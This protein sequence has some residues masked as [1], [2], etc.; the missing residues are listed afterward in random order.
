MPS[1][2]ESFR[3]KQVET[4]EEFEAYYRLRWERLRKPWHQAEG[5]EQDDIEN[6]C[7][8]LIA[9]DKKKNVIGVARLQ[10]NN[11]SE[12]QIRYMAV[13]AEHQNRGI[14]HALM[15]RL[16]AHALTLG[17]DHIML[18]ARENA[19]GF[20][21]K[22]GYSTEAKSYLLFGEIQHFRMYKQLTS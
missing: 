12:A 8:H 13:N 5:S 17:H 19:T 14:G 9:V 2:T 3:I 21:T 16:E 10:S 18:N 4:E 1:H 11:R 22:L 20:Y 6:Q 15:S 7:Y